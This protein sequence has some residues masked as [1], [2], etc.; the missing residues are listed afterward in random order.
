MSAPKPIIVYVDDQAPNLTVFESELEDRWDVK[1]FTN[2]LEALRS[3][4]TLK[5]CIIVSDQRMPG[6]SG[7]DYL[8]LAR[9][10]HPHAIRIIVTGYSDEQLVI[11]SVRKAQVFDYI[12]KPWQ[13]NE[14]EAAM[15]RAYEFYCKHEEARALQEELMRKNQELIDLTGQLKLAHS[16]EEAT[17]KELEAWVHPIALR[18]T[19]DT[20]FKFPFKKDLVGITFDVIEGARYHDVKVEGVPI[21]KRIIEEFSKILLKH[22]GYRESLPGDSVYG[23]FGLEDSAD[24]LC[25]RGLAAA[26]E[27]RIALGTVSSMAG[28]P[29]ECGIAVH[30]MRGCTIDV[31]RAEASTTRGLLVQRSVGTSGVSI[32]LLHRLEKE[33]H[34]LKGSNIV[35]TK[36]LLDH[37]HTRPNRV[38]ALG[39]KLLKGQTVATEMYLLPSNQLTDAEIENFCLTFSGVRELAAAA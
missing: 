27:F 24:D 9:K 20:S 19:K 39:S 1:T 32:D 8:D 33:V 4:E 25:Q 38:L 11:E 7:V 5:P 18:I 22:G 10:I 13:E 16:Q 34:C 12:R 31:H 6:L 2:P 29:I 30:L 23:H 21:L 17:R 28:T 3:L 35:C 15:T 37:L 14:L 36:E 26:Q